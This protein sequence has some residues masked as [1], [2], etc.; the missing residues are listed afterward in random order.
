MKTTKIKAALL[1]GI[2]LSA[3]NVHALT[4]PLDTAYVTP[5]VT[6]AGTSPWLQAIFEDKAF[7][8]VQLTLAATGLAAGTTQSVSNWFFNS[9]AITSGPLKFDYASGEEALIIQGPNLRKAGGDR[10]F[11]IEFDFVT[12][13]F[14]PGEQSIYLI[15]SFD[16]LLPISSGSFDFL[17]VSTPP[18]LTNFYS[19]AL[20]EGISGGQSSWIAAATAQT[21]GPGPGPAP[22]PEPATMLLLGT[23][24][25]GLVFFGPRKLLK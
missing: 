9:D 5:T 18:T 22:I 16:P 20:V 7:N 12:G 4:F 25:T 23:G 3:V 6:P 19:A 2:L 21:P 1:L 10:F 15:S 14:A 17:S 11:D 13:Q 8:S 24:L